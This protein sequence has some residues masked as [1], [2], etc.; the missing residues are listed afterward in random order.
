MAPFTQGWFSCDLG[1]EHTLGN[2]IFL[3]FPSIHLLNYLL[4]AVSWFFTCTWSHMGCS[5]RG[6]NYVSYSMRKAHIKRPSC[7][8]W[9][10]VPLSKV[11]LKKLSQWGAWCFI[12]K[13][14][15]WGKHLGHFLLKCSVGINFVW[16]RSYD[17]L[18]SPW[19]VLVP[20]GETNK[21]K[22]IKEYCLCQEDRL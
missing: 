18:F 10:L 5:A 21:H 14:F 9:I 19:K 22:Q 3:C 17:H 13:A 4:K 1:S 12:T 15:L 20:C 7:L 8:H 11:N 16:H 6:K 2:Q